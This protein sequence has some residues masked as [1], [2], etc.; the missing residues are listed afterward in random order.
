MPGLL[1]QCPTCLTASALALL[2]SFLKTAIRTVLQKHF[3]SC[4]SYAQNL[5]KVPHFICVTVN[6]LMLMRSCVIWSLIS[7]LTSFPAAPSLPQFHSKQLLEHSRHK[8]V[9]VPH[10]IVP[11]ARNVLSVDSCELSSLHLSN[12]CSTV[13]FLPYLKLQSTSASNS[14]SLLFFLPYFVSFH[15]IL[16]YIVI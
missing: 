15:I 2:Q 14:L 1:Q 12:L 5:P 4:H 6:N 13:T 8:A 3:R 9:S 7:S 10:L 11:S 16:Y